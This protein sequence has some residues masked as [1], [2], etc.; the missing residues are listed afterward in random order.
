MNLLVTGGAGFIGSNFVRH[1]RARHP[2]DAITVLDALTYAGNRANLDGV[3]NVEF[4]HG[5]IR[6]F[7][8]ASRLLRERDIDTL[9]H[10]AAETHVD[11]SIAGPD[12]F[13]E[14]NVLGTHVLLRAAREVW[15]GRGRPHRF[16]HVSTDEVYGSL[17]PDEPPFTEQSPFRPSSPYAASKAASDLLVR[18]YH[19]TYGL[20]TSVSNCCNNFGP[21]QFPEKLVPLFVIN[22]LTGRPLPVY[23]D[24]GNV[25]SWLQVED[26]CR[27][28]ELAVEK[29]RAGETYNIG[30]DEMTNLAVAECLCAA[31]DS[32]FAARP[33]LARRY[34]NCPAAEGRPT[35][36]LRTFVE[37]RPGHDRR[38][39]LDDGKAR[40]ELGYAPRRVFAQALRETVAW[41]A[42]NEAW[43]RRAPGANAAE[44]A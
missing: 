14:T 1:W 27:A 21:R 34:P 13:V 6:D 16:H 37:D 20:Q 9:V 29:G 24:G 40:R 11:R 33:A 32:L 35:A 23:G 36:A 22:A 10:F 30:G 7:D 28:I 31:I 38:Y 17:A 43:W 4:V 2:A 12:R 44:P 8:L 19:R 5:D 26:C 18:V 41:Y 39:A 3:E 25:R 42:D 15:L